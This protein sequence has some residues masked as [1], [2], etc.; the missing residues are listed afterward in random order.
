M[1]LPGLAM[2]PRLSIANSMNMSSA[3]ASWKSKRQYYAK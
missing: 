3:S 2:P 1:L